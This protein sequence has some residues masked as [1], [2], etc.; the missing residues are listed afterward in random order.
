LFLEVEIEEDC[1][2]KGKEVDLLPIADV[3]VFVGVFFLALQ[4]IVMRKLF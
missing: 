1:R 3:A 4:R 2:N